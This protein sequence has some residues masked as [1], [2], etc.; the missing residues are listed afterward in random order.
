MAA[1]V[2][3]LEHEGYHLNN[4]V[5]QRLQCQPYNYGQMTTGVVSH[6]TALGT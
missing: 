3:G 1:K 5:L 2:E 6:Q 4:K